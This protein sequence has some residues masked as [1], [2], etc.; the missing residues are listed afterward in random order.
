MY[1]SYKALFSIKWKIYSI[2]DK[3]LARPIPLDVVGMFALLL[4][5]SLL[6]SKPCA[7]IL[8][9]PYLGVV[10]LLNGIL[11]YLMMKLDPQGR[12]ALVFV[13]DLI[14]FVV[15]PK[16]IDF[17]GRTVKPIRKEEFYWDALDLG[18]I[19]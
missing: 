15:K 11:T 7:A 4:P 16:T 17:S 13:F 12:P 1:N 18:S 5:L 3:P 14:S 2:G 6:L 8:N 9:Q 10:V 19:E